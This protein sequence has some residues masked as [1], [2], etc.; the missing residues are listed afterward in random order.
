MEPSKSCLGLDCRLGGRTFNPRG[1]CWTSLA[2]RHDWPD[3]EQD[4][5]HQ[6]HKAVPAIE[7]IR[8]RQHF[9][10]AAEKRSRGNGQKAAENVK[11]HNVSHAKSNDAEQNELCQKFHRKVSRTTPV[12]AYK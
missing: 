11:A 10:G 8:L 5:R 12:A 6:N 1:A 7:R 2:P 9:R 4:Q 3:K